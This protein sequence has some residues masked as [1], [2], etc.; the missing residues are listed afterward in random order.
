MYTVTQF[1]FNDKSIHF[2][3]FRQFCKVLTSK[4][5]K[6]NLRH[7]QGELCRVCTFSTC[8]KL[9]ICG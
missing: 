5:V 2:N 9:H 4:I 1:T 7:V 3:R 8:S 6:Y